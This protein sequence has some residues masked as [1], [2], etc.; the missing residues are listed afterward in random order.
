M[1]L[2]AF[3]SKDILVLANHLQQFYGIM[4]RILTWDILWRRASGAEPACLH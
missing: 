4:E 3:Q 2:T 1:L